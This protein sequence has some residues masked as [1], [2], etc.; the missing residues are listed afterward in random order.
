MLQIALANTFL[1]S[2]AKIPPAQ[3]KKVRE[4]ITRFR[5]NPTAASI[6]YEPI[7][8]ARDS[9]MRTVRIDQAYR[10]IVIHPTKGNTYILVWVDHHDQAMDWGCRRTFD[11]NAVTGALQVIDVETVEQMTAPLSAP[12]KAKSLDEYGPFETFDDKNLLRTGLPA[13]LLPAIKALQTAEDL[14]KLRPYLPEESYEA[15]YWI[16]NFGYSVDQALAEVVAGKPLTIDLDDLDTALTHP[17]SQRRFATIKS[18][19]D[20]IEM[21]NA[22]L[23]KWRIFLHPSQA[24][25]VRHFFNG[26][27]QVL[28][29][30]G[31]GK[32]VVAMHRACYLV[33][34]LFTQPTDRVLLTTFSRNLAENIKQNM[35]N[36]CQEAMSR[37]EVTSIH[38]WAINFLRNQNIQLQPATQEEV[39][40]C[41]R[42][43]FS[44]VG[45]GTWDEQFFKT[46]W[47]EVVQQH[48][49]TSKAEYLRAPRTGRS[50]RVSRKERAEI[51]EVLAEYQQNLQRL[52]KLEW[53]EIVRQTRLY[54]EQHPNHLPYKAIV[55]DET[56]DCHP[57]DLK[58]L[59]QMVSV[60]S[61]DLFF[62]G[63][64]HQR[65]YGKPVVMSH[66]GI[67]IRGRSKKLKI[68]YRT[69]E[70]IRDWSV[71]VLKNVP[72]DDLDGGLDD[73]AKS[74]TSLLNGVAP[75]IRHFTSLSEETAFL[76]ETIEILQLQNVA[77]ESI[78]LV[79]RT[80]RQLTQDYIPALQKAGISYLKL[81]RDTQ[82]AGQL[83]LRVATMHRVKGLEFNHV[84]I[85]GVN[86]GVIPLSFYPP[87]T[88]QDGVIETEIQERCLLHVAV[89]RARDSLTVTSFGIPS[90]FLATG[91]V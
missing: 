3:Q 43:V 35:K 38:R 65:I 5:Q 58:L 87:N 28:G 61:N 1:E 53:S 66:C 51:W 46:E 19:N 52:G 31:T 6:N 50:V 8:Q 47:V 72:I 36:L 37:L 84:L 42:D 11:I 79:A 22:P 78:C 30:A 85:A 62:V 76:M 77:L 20:L 15:L 89:T 7:A 18:D 4:F 9:K 56:Q 68:N 48:G 23:E 39:E 49:V 64:A 17:D 82:E 91:A 70:E 75:V 29:G 12:L 10:A 14:D 33:N 73:H 83:G 16:A 63:D 57:E 60:G 81:E 34:E 88:N 41:W 90:P 54:L 74:Y 2:F 69:T 86:E 44:A 13:L 21:L 32:T 27:V 24:K 55:V 80:H 67:N 59:R 45:T 26:P 25:L 40:E 71:S